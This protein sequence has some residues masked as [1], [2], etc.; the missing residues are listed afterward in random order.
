MV[1][2]G[3]GVDVVVE[4]EVGVIMIE[5]I[6][7]RAGSILAAYTILGVARSLWYDYRA[8]RRDIPKYIERSIEAHLALSHVAF[9][10]LRESR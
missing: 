10:R 7:S 6:E 1:E 4:C 8:G 5:Q 9:K 3:V 2:V